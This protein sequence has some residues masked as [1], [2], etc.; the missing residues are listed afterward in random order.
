MPMRCGSCSVF[1]LAAVLGVAGLGVG[2]YTYFSNGGPCCGEKPAEHAALVSS[3]DCGTSCCS[4]QEAV[5]LKTDSACCTEG[6]APVVLAAQEPAE[7]SCCTGEAKQACKDG[8]DG[9]TGDGKNGC[10]GGCEG[11]KAEQAAASGAAPTGGKN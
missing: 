3:D 4:G 8:T 2:G 6:E 11:E 7:S 5:A 9:C 10:C 1:H